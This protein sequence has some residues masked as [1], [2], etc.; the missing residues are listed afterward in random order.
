MIFEFPE[1]AEGTKTRELVVM[2]GHRPIFNIGMNP[3]TKHC[4]LSLRDFPV[5]AQILDDGQ[6]SAQATVR[7]YRNEVKM[8]P[9]K[10]KKD[11]VERQASKEK[12][13]I[14]TEASAEVERPKFDPLAFIKNDK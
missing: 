6:S 1:C 12:L 13:N 9:V 2:L 3:Q 10:K 8:E 5:V 14:K 7:E 11:K 4:T